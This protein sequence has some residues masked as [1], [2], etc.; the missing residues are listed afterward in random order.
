MSFCIKGYVLCGWLCV[1]DAV[2]FAAYSQWPSHLMI[3]QATRRKNHC[4]D[5]IRIWQCGH[6]SCRQQYLQAT[7]A[8]VATLF[9][10]TLNHT[11]C[12][13]VTISL[14]VHFSVIYSMTKLR[15]VCKCS[16]LHVDWKLSMKLRWNPYIILLTHILDISSQQFTLYS[17]IQE[18]SDS[19]DFSPMASF[20]IR[21][22]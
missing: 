4:D 14:R 8:V 12:R 6:I 21:P 11:S 9:T 10:C 2:L 16:Q 18:H 13:Q 5:N 1:T 17:C 22:H 19:G 15:A 20:M 7:S 3:E